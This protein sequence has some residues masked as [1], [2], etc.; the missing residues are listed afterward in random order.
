MNPDQVPADEFA[1]LVAVQFSALPEW[2]RQ[3]VQ[4]VAILTEDAPPFEEVVP[5]I[6]DEII[7]LH[8]VL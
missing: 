4:E 7:R 2:V 8:K 3:A 5:K 6:H 1:A